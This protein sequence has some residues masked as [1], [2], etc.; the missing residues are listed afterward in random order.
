LLQLFGRLQICA[1]C[2]TNA[3]TNGCVHQIAAKRTIKV[4]RFLD[5]VV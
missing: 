2:V 5:A 3:G 4:R 1:V